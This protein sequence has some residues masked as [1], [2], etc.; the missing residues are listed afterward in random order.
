MKQVIIIILFLLQ[1]SWLFAQQEKS[2]IHKG[3]QLYQQQK[4]TEAEAN[5]RKAVEQKNQNV[6]G[7]FNLGD[8]L[9]KQKKFDEAGKQFTTFASLQ[10]SRTIA[11]A[12]ALAAC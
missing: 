1:G 7:N 10:K 11:M 6:T 9:Y 12:F 4:Y 2:Y 3:N 8:A 5:Y